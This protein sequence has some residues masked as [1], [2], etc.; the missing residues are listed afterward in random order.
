MDESFLVLFFKKEPLVREEERQALLF[1]KRS[2][3]LSFHL[4]S[5]SNVADPDAILFQKFNAACFERGL[6]PFQQAAGRADLGDADHD[7]PHSEFYKK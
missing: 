1:E 3:K 5:R 2:K 6:G 4:G 7:A